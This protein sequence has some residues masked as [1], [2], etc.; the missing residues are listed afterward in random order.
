MPIA[1][2]YS[3]TIIILYFSLLKI[4]FQKLS[5]NVSISPCSDCSD[6]KLKAF[7]GLMAITK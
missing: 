7:L 4:Q 2:L 6:C 5:K 3:Y 1:I